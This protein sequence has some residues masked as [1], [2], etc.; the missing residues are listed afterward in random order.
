MMEPYQQHDIQK[1]LDKLNGGKLKA[2]VAE[3]QASRG[4]TRSSV[5]TIEPAEDAPDSNEGEVGDKDG[6]VTT[7]RS[8]GQRIAGH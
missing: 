1:G 6:D 8:S 5:G 3:S 2:S 4:L 7:K